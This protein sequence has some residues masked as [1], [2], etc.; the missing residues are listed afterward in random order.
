[1]FE[2]FTKLTLNIK[3]MVCFVLDCLP[4]SH[5]CVWCGLGCSY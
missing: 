3:E 1:M 5:A 4:R 2:T